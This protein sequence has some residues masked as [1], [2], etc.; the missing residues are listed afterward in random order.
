MNFILMRFYET[1]N[2]YARCPRNLKDAMTRANRF[3][4]K[5]LMI[6]LLICFA[7]G[8]GADRFFLQKKDLSALSDKAARLEQK[9]ELEAERSK[10][11]LAQYEKQQQMLAASMEQS[12]LSFRVL[13][14]QI[15][16][17]HADLS[18]KLET[19][20]PPE[21]EPANRKYPEASGTDKLLIGRIERVRLTP[22]E[23]VFRARIDTGATT[24]S[25][26]ARDIETFERDGSPWVRFHL[27]DAEED[28][29]YEIEKPVVR[30]AR[31]LQ[32]SD[33]EAER[34]PVVKLQCQIGRIKI[35]EEFTLEGRAHMDYKVLIGRNI[36]QDLMVVDVA[37]KYIAPLPKP[38]DNGKAA[39]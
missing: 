29:L 20:Q 36:L 31:I 35:I 17:A 25:L 11:L 28:S 32:A 4:A 21:P 16:Q 14:E 15:Q 5:S 12:L 1:I 2:K 26:D 19:L 10:R 33:M 3:F 38:D 22:P 37:Q 34:R 30:H 13:E 7:A 24:S 27:K 39:Q 23:H 6:L 9:A 8:C 18:R